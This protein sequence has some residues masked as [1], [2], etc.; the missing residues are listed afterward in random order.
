VKGDTGKEHPLS[1][2][3]FSERIVSAYFT[4]WNITPVAFVIYGWDMAVDNREYEGTQIRE[5]G[6][7]A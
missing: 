6:D 1:Q 7:L 5:R 2:L 3:M 4:T